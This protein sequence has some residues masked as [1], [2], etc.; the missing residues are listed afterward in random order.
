[1]SRNKI[2][3]PKG[4]DVEVANEHFDAEA[5]RLEKQIKQLEI[6]GKRHIAGKPA[7]TIAMLDLEPGDCF[8][9]KNDQY[10]RQFITLDKGRSHIVAQDQHGDTQAH[11]IFDLFCEV[12]LI[13]YEF[14]IKAEVPKNNP[15][16]QRYVREFS[17]G[18][19]LGMDE[20]HEGEKNE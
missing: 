5:N 8:E 2:R 20:Y 14:F 15:S 12:V 18:D 19:W 16:H 6:A 9:I 3:N 7:G 1:M 17:E 10:Q 13:P 4:S 11:A